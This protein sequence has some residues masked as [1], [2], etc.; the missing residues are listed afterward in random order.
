MKANTQTAETF[1][2]FYR[3]RTKKDQITAMAEEYL[4]EHTGIEG[5]A[6]EKA[7]LAL[8]LSELSAAL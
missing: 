8:V 2:E 5:S 4:Q 6:R 1:I 3:R 7:G